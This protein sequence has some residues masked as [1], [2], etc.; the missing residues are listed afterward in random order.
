MTV[1][2]NRFTSASYQITGD[3]MEVP[4]LSATAI[5]RL[6]D[7][8]IRSTWQ[9]IGYFLDS[10]RS[11]TVFKDFLDGCDAPAQ[12]TAAIAR[13]IAKR[14]AEVGIKVEVALPTNVVQS[15]RIT[16]DS[17]DAF[18]RRAFTGVLNEDFQGF[19]MGQPGKPSASVANLAGAG[20]T[21]TDMLF[22]AFLKKFDGP[23]GATSAS[24]AAEFYAELKDK[25][26]YGVAAGYSATVVDAIKAQLDIGLDRTERRRGAPERI[27]EEEVEHVVEPE[28]PGTDERVRR[29]PA[30]V[31]TGASAPNLGQ[32]APAARPRA[33]AQGKS[34]GGS[35]LGTTVIQMAALGFGAYYVY[36]ALQQQ[37]RELV[38]Y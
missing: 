23:M 22:A 20:I 7:H 15:S 33:Q 28:P 27:T 35:G 8:E 30:A 11:E 31:D 38:V 19:G 1:S 24:R 4:N 32:A 25:A 37:S 36:T 3:L 13:A 2:F 17:M 9:L 5:R 18:L 12:H 26:T 29:R 6:G 16:D 14:V 10:G 34:S 21:T